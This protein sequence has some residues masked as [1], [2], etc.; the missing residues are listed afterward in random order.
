MARQSPGGIAAKAIAGIELALW[1][2]KAKALG[3]P[4][5]ELFGGPFRLRQPLYWSHCGTSRAMNAAVIGVPP[6][7]TMDDVHRLGEEVVRRGYRALKTNIVYP[8]IRRGRLRFGG[9][10]GPPTRRQR[11]DD[12]RPRDAP[13]HI[14][15]RR[16]AERRT[17]PRP[18]PRH[19]AEAAIRVCRCSRARPMWVE[20]HLRRPAVREVK[21][22]APM[23]ICSGKN[24]S[25]SAAGA[26]LRGRDERRH[27]RR[28]V[29][30][31]RQSRSR[32]AGQTHEL[33]VAPNNSYSRLSTS[34][35]LHLCGTHPERRII[36]IDVDDVPGW[37]HEPEG[38]ARSGRR[39]RPRHRVLRAPLVLPPRRA[40]GQGPGGAAGRKISI[41]PEGSGTRAL[42]LQLLA[43]QRLNQ[44]SAQML[45]LSHQAATE[46]LIRGEIEAAL[47]L[48]A[49][50]SPAVRQLVTEDGIVLVSFPRADT[51]VAL[52][53]FLSKLTL[54]A[55]AGRHGE[56][57][58]A[59][60]GD[61]VRAQG[62]PGGAQGLA[63]RDPVL[64][65]RCG[66]AGPFRTG[67]LPAGEA[68]PGRGSSR[69]TPR[70]TRRASTSARAGRSS[71]VTCPSGSRWRSAGFSSS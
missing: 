25:A 30:R 2:L 58:A 3:V 6:F 23:P 65:P 63:P 33:K 69:L 61:P 70:P 62:Q 59:G 16:R 41:G 68:A 66:G 1:D 20:T 12:P 40:R 7:R 22:A 37:H 53:P 13:R 55:G 27:H 29:G 38:V 50:D 71:S 43:R 42:V 56:E 57:P 54:P 35:S 18:Q 44:D 14:P 60:G 15:A 51:Y 67:N 8:L 64:A 39:R 47:M 46:A 10:P 4:V 17:R 21:D 36:E 28:P 11:P 32:G 26:V 49:W 5:A 19:E 45:A 52:Y 24:L 31:L 34:H 48:A 9:G